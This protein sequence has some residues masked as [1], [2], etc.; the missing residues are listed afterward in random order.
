[1][2]LA[3]AA[4]VFC[5]S[6][7]P[8][9]AGTA[10]NAALARLVFSEIYNKHNFAVAATIYAPDFVNHGLTRDIGLAEDQA[11]AKMWCDMFPDLHVVQQVADGDLVTLMWIAQATKPGTAEHLK[12]R[13]IT[14]WRVKDGHLAEEWSEFDERK[15]SGSD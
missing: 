8:A 6:V 14:I 2:K 1:L 11:A 15:A 12:V 3:I 10:D 13:G 9:F 7:I 5:A 4:A